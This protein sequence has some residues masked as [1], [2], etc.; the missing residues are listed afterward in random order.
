MIGSLRLCVTSCEAPKK[1]ATQPAAA[2]ASAGTSR[3]ADGSAGG[4]SSKVSTASTRADRAMAETIQ[5][6]GRQ[7]S[8]SAWRPPMVGPSATAP[9]MHMFMIMPVSFSLLAGKPS[10]SGGTAAISSRLVQR[11]ARTWPVMYM[12]TFWAAAVSTKP[13]TRMVA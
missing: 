9:K 8:A 12:A 6:S 1:A 11:P 4:A 3:G 10:D 13:M 2:S 7:A 5:N